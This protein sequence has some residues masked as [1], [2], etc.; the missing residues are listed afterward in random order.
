MHKNIM[1]SYD[2]SKESLHALKEAQE[3]LATSP[4]MKLYIVQV[5]SDA[6]IEAPIEMGW[7]GTMTDYQTVD[8]AVLAKLH[9]RFM[10]H[11]TQQLHDELDRAVADIPN[12]VEMHVAVQTIS[13]SDSLLDFAKHHDVDLIIMGCR[14]L[15]AIRGVL[16]SVSYAVLRSSEVPVLIVK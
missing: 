5:A 16:G 9:D 13:V 12:P 15:G 4:Q 6:E 3:I 10:E 8:P 14:G 1:V 7:Y 11:K 2:G